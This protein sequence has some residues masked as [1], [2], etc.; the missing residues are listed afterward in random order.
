MPS[1]LEA[2]QHLLDGLAGPVLGGVGDLG[3]GR[4]PAQLFE[5]RQH[6]TAG[7]GE[8]VGGGVPQLPPPSPVEG[9][10]GVDLGQVTAHQPDDA[11]S[12]TPATEQ[13]QDVST[14]P[15]I[16]VEPERASM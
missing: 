4:L 8:L 14:A 10:G 11:V 2:P 15:V 12:L 5:G 6:L 16:P 9:V 1:A 7:L 3:A 13:H